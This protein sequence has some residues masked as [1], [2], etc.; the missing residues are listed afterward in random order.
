MWLTVHH[1]LRALSETNRRKTSR[2]P[3]V[4]TYRP[5]LEA[6]EDRTLLSAYIVTTTADNGDNT[7]PIAG[8]LRDAIMHVNADTNHTLYASPSDPS[9]D[10]I[11]FNITAA[12]DTGFNP[13]TGVATIK[14]LSVL[15]PSITNS[16]IINGYTQH[17]AS[18]NTLPNSD[19]AVLEIALD[20][21]LINPALPHWPAGLTI[22]ADNCVVQGLDIY[23]FGLSTVGG[24]ASISNGIW[25]R[26]GSHNHIQGN[27]IGT[28]ISGTSAP[29]GLPD[30]SSFSVAGPMTGGVHVTDGASITGLVPTGMASTIRANGTLSRQRAQASPFAARE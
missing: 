17:G 7:N 15:L 29:D 1:F 11:D 19:N 9:V 10:E 20:G 28:D 21:S 26:G 12:S 24:N 13:T 14:P 25:I 16:V 18:E 30:Y 8:S 23:G 6:L 4:S 5:R 22:T 27:F 2:R 3:R